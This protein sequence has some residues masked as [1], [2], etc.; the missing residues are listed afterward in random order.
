MTSSIHTIEGNLV[1]TGKKFAIVA[2]RW[3]SFVSERLVEGAIDTIVRHGGSADDVTIVRVP[4]SFELPMAVQKVAQTGRYD[5]VL[6]LGALI[7]GATPHFDYIAAE[8]T[9]GVASASMQ[10]GVPV[11][12]GIITTNTLEQAIERSGSK[13]G[14][15]GSEAAQAAIEMANLYQ[16]LDEAT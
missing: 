10:T 6:A 5:A 3:N 13:V 2:S 7:R 1:A 4:G 14:N 11:A 9:K 12:Y 16:Q 15:K 8:A